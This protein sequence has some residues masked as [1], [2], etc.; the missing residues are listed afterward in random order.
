MIVPPRISGAALRQ[1]ARLARTR[2]GALALKQVFLKDLGIAEL[3]KLD[4]ALFGEMPV[5]SR[6][7]GGRAP[8]APESAELAAPAD[9]AWSGTSAAYTDAYRSGRAT[10]RDVA[11]RALAAA[12][13]LGARR[14]NVGPIMAYCDADALAEADASTARW[15]DGKPL[16]PLDGVPFAVKE[17]TA[18]R[19]LPMLGGSTFDDP[20]P[21]RE[22]ATIV[23]RL[24]AAGAIVI[25]HTP[26]TEYGMTPLGYN[27]KRAMP[28]NPHATD[29][30]AGG[31][32]TGSGVAVATGLVPFA[33]GADGGG[34]IRIPSALNGVFGIKPTWGR[35][36]RAGNMGGGT[37]AHVG[38]LASST[39]D[40]ARVLDV[41]AAP[42]PLD[43]QTDLAPALE[44]QQFERALARGVRGLRI[45]VDEHEWSEA[46][47]VVAKV[48]R[49]ALRALEKEGA[50]LV[51]LE[52]R[53]VRFAAAIGYLT[54]GLEDRAA[55]R[56][57]I[58]ERLE[59]FNLDLQI[60]YAVLGTLGVVEYVD[61][62]RLRSGLREEMKALFRDRIDLFALP[63]TAG[64]ATRVTDAEMETGFL[65]ARALDA[66]CRFNFLGNLTGLPALSAPVGLDAE[67]LPLGLQLVGDA[68]DE[69][70]VLAASAHLER[71][72]AAKVERPRVHVDVLA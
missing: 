61:G 31:S 34:S 55:Q 60:T 27:P 65:D 54:I 62:Q 21:Q 51:P 42:D 50:I 3:E 12:R 48:G 44:W 71:I 20:T 17:Q 25:G 5:D 64:P 33:L 19:G 22:D 45:G 24:R 16:G 13:D 52:T 14:P 66:L 40:L 35:V 6:A 10:P 68:W 18:V 63:T 32:S 39:L 11:V 30:V 36:S 7:L 67:G 15:R 53:L 56:K 1:I 4:D 70:T 58:R 46:T 29:R 57:H 47:E 8:R 9:R 69:A 49:E 59:E 38:P 26:M 41:V 43:P 28:R 2:V 72:G 37:V 23:A